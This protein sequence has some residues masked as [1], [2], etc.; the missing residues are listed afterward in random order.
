MQYWKQSSKIGFKTVNLWW[1]FL[2]CCYFVDESHIL[3]SAIIIVRWKNSLCV[4]VIVCMLF[5]TGFLH[6]SQSS[7]KWAMWPRMALNLWSFLDLWVLGFFSKPLCSASN[8]QVGTAEELVTFITVICVYILIWMEEHKASPATNMKT[9]T[10]QF[11]LFLKQTQTFTMFMMKL[12]D[13]GFLGLFPSQNYCSQ[14]Y[15]NIGLKIL[16]LFVMFF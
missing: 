4:L 3:Q 15:L 14:W 10:T 6:V 7:F 1:L 5:E 9:R 13:F 16:Y 11:I 8:Y 2:L 12:K